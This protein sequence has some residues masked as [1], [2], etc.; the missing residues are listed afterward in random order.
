MKYERENSNNNSSKSSSSSKK[1]QQ[2]RAHKIK[3]HASIWLNVAKTVGS[4][5]T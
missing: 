5:H 3:S 4:E 2:Q 1:R